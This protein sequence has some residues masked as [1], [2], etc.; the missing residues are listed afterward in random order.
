MT[1]ETKVVCIGEP[2]VH[3]FLSTS[4]ELKHW[5]WQYPIENIQQY[6]IELKNKN[7]ETN[8]KL[9][10]LVDNLFDSTGKN[11]VFETTFVTFSE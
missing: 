4:N 10:F 7:I 11:K 3:E 9:V 1:K 8:P 6:Y 2:R 5:N